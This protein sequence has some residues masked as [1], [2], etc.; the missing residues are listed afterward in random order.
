M[1]KIE[2]M[3]G[4][5]LEVMKGMGDDGK[6]DQRDVC[7][8]DWHAFGPW[9]IKD[10]GDGTGLMKWLVPDVINEKPVKG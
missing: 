4:D 6:K 9:M 10:N 8:G 5:C 2:L 7:D 3:Q 1:P